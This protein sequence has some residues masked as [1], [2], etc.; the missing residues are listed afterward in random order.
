MIYYH[1]GGRKVVKLLVVDLD[2]TLLDNKKHIKDVDK[3]AIMKA[4]ERGVKVSIFTGRNYYSAKKYLEELGLDVPVVFQNGALIMDFKSRK[5]LRMVALDGNLAREAV[6]RSRNYGVFYIVYKDFLSDKDMLLDSDY[7]G[8]YSYY[9]E[10]NSW[11]ILKV[12]D[13]LEYVEGEVAEVALIGEEKLIKKVTSFVNSSDASVIKSTSLSG[14]SFYEIFGPDVSKAKALEFLL[15]TFGVDRSEVMFI[16]DGY[17]DLEIMEVV[18]IGVAMGNAPDD[19][20]ERA[21]FVTLSNEEG[22]VA[23]AINRFILEK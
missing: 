2:G 19:V 20:K 12:E 11:R 13:V 16:G 1:K 18:G 6:V 14:H 7:N 9:L 10:N 3:R 8:P 4:M 23:H 22:G 5:V 17:N 21:S 15:S